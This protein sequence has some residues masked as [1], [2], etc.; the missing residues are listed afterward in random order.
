[1]SWTAP[2]T[3]VTGEVLTA[4]I[5]N[6]D[7]RDNMKETAAATAQSA[8]DLVYADAANSMGS[9]LGIGVANTVLVSDG[10][11]PVW[12]SPKFD[13]RTDSTTGTNTA[14]QSLGGA[15]W[16]NDS[17]QVEVEMVTGTRALVLFTS[18]LSNANAGQSTYVSFDVSNATTS[19]GGDARSI[20]YES[21]AANDSI[22]LSGAS[23]VTLT[24]GTNKFQLIGKVSGGTG[25]IA[26]ADI[27][28]LPF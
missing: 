3:Y 26:Q 7:L 18:F 12:R 15:A 10:S 1:M 21:G 24:A 17:D 6:T 28:V 2:R 20:R 9:R 5:F 4:A 14:Y 25:T 23:Y 8:G 16:F 27:F 13:R 11:G 22:R 19:A